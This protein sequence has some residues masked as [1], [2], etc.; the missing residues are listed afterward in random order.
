MG[1]DATSNRS[2]CVMREVTTG[3]DKTLAPVT[4]REQGHPTRDASYGGTGGPDPERPLLQALRSEADEAI[5][6]QDN[7]FIETVLPH[8]IQRTRSAEELAEYRRQFAEPGEGRRPTLMWPRE[9]PIDGEP[10]DVAA[11]AADYADWLATSEAPKL[12]LKTEPGAILRCRLGICRG[13]AMNQPLERI[14]APPR[15]SPHVLYVNS[16]RKTPLTFLQRQ[17]PGHVGV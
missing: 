12:F 17:H 1:G 2:F 4:Q 3:I 15:M 8:A 9:I 16:G 14:D 11:I 7:L 6:L 10:A 13:S 5:I